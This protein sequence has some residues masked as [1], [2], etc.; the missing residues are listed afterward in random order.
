MI[1]LHFKRLNEPLCN[2][3]LSNQS[4]VLSSDNSAYEE[5]SIGYYRDEHDRDGDD[6]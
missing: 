1:F 3:Q 6:I 4:F 5:Y 2:Q